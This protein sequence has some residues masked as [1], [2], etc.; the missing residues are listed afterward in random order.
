MARQDTAETQQANAEAQSASR[1]GAA[2]AQT[3][4][5]GEAER[6]TRHGLRGAAQVATEEYGGPII[7]FMRDTLSGTLH[8]TGTVAADAVDVVRDV[9]T[10]AVHATEEIGAETLGAVNTLGSGV[11]ATARD[12]LVGGVSGI[13][14]VLGSA[15][16][17]R[18]APPPAADTRPQGSEASPRP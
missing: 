6:D 16:P 13:R 1:S 11:V 2:A 5:T 12:I 3:G 8:A 9:L 7:G 18:R 4:P 14:Q 17:E 10:G 15:M